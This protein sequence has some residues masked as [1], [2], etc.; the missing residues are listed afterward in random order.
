MGKVYTEITDEIADWIAEQKIFFVGTAAADGLINVSPKGLDTLK[1]K[2]PNRLIWLNL[3]GSGNETAAHLY[4]HDRITIML[5]AF[6]GKPLILR[7]YGHAQVIQAND[8]QW[9]ELL[10]EF[11]LQSG[12]RQVIDIKI[13][14]VQT[15]C[16]FGVPL[17]KFED[18][19]NMLTK[20]SDGKGD[21]GI[22]DYWKEKNAISLDGKPTGIPVE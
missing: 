18:E 6:E 9:N 14:K 11:P 7:I 16:G 15:S 5:C 2:S 1:V 8:E 12:A 10:S 3:T 19:R 17:M 21:N 13:D 20:W 4:E 22:R